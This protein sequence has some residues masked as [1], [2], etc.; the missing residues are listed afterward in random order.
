M[1]YAVAWL[2]SSHR[3][4]ESFGGENLE[5]SDHMEDQNRNVTK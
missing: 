5:K 1:I 2:Y 3:K 4:K